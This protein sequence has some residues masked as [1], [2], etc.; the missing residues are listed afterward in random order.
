MAA[1]EHATGVEA[2]DDEV[3]HRHNC[4]QHLAFGNLLLNLAHLPGGSGGAQDEVHFLLARLRNGHCGF[5]GLNRIQDGRKRV[6]YC[7]KCVHA[8]ML[9]NALVHF[10]PP[11]RQTIESNG[12]KY[13]FHL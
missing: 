10:G 2:G 9:E 8:P 1:V 5:H 7:K 13:I 4:V 12:Q 3:G 6:E 11:G